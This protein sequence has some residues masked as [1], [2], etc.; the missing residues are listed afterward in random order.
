MQSRDLINSFLKRYPETELPQSFLDYVTEQ[1]ELGHVIRRAKTGQPLN[2]YLE[3]LGVAQ[4]AISHVLDADSRLV[5]HTNYAQLL[6]M[7][8]EELDAFF[9]K[10]Y[11]TVF[12]LQELVLDSETLTGFNRHGREH[13]KTV[14]R[15]LMTLLECEPESGQ[16]QATL[17]EAI[18]AGYLHDVGNLLSRKEHGVYGLY[19]LTQ[20]FAN[21][22]ESPETLASLMRV[23]EA[24]LFHEVDFGSRVSSLERLNP[25]T[26]ALIVADKTDVSFRRVSQKSNVSEA[27]QDA[28]TLVNLLTADSQIQCRK[29]SF[30]WEIHFSPSMRNGDSD[31]FPALLKRAERVWVPDE[32][33]RLYRREN[34]EYVFI[35]N[36]TFLR[37]YLARLS[38]AV[39]AV[40]ALRPSIQ[41]F[42]LVIQDDERGVSLTRKFTREDHNEKL[43]L[44]HNNL[45]KNYREEVAGPV[46]G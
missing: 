10:R 30:Q 32:W 37:L 35:F 9:A 38:F 18:V 16:A 20:F 14:T 23:L 44:I 39:R 31:R 17:Q 1:E 13:L 8:P 33:Q 6:A 42:Q 36:A 19:L 21:V 3:S 15:R 24:V 22:D 28:H 46:E 12:V 2:A 40:F 5:Q 25:V 45:F 4:H 29:K 26:L 11:E 43:S 34:I 41:T 7:S 27:V